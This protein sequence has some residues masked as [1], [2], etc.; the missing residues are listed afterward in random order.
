MSSSNAPTTP[1]RPVPSEKQIN[2]MAIVM[3]NVQG[4]P[5]IDWENVAA[6]SGLKNERTAKETY[7]QMQKKLGWNSPAGGSG[8]GSGA[9][10]T[11]TKVQKRT[12]KVGT[13]AAA[14]TPSKAAPKG[15]GKKVAEQDE[16][17]VKDNGGEEGTTADG[18]HRGESYVKEDE[19]EDEE[20]SDGI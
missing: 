17:E 8:S 2:F 10:A 6:V 7:R 11:P 15:R 3:Q 1:S 12:G 9:Q 16:E 4:K 14:K 18:S 19:E 20:E 5:E 13:K